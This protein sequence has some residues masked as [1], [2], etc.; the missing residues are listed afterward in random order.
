[1][2]DAAG[3]GEPL[4]ASE[5]V[6]AAIRTN[7]FG[8]PDFPGHLQ[9]LKTM[10]DGTNSSGQRAMATLG[11]YFMS[12]QKY[13]EAMRLLTDATD[14]ATDLQYFA[15]AFLNMGK[16]HLIWKDKDAAHI[17]FMKS[18]RASNRESLYYLAAAAED[19]TDNQKEAYEVAALGG[20]HEASHNLG[21]VELEMIESRPE[22]PK[23]M[24]DY[25][26][27]REWFQVAATS[28][29]VPSMLNM[30]LICKS[31]GE[32]ESGI[33]WL[34]NAEKWLE[35]KPSPELQDRAKQIRKNWSSQ[36]VGITAVDSGYCGKIDPFNEVRET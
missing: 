14:W 30:A 23:T 21:D 29:F 33:A 8:H 24:I 27:A 1:M 12:Q 32:K 35:K 31:V 15:Q 18:A 34:E 11:N 3:L 7:S 5:L 6:E 36:E 13:K 2:V 22:K 17:A 10:A 19:G 25:G 4:A 26:M 9:M 20:I 28:N 16:I